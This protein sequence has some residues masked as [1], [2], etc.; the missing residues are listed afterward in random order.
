MAGTLWLPW[1]WLCGRHSGSCGQNSD[2][3]GVKWEE[4]WDGETH[5]IPGSL[6]ACCVISKS[7]ITSLNVPFLIQK[8]TIILSFQF[9]LLVVMLI[10]WNYG[11]ISDRVS[12][13]LPKFGVLWLYLPRTEPRSKTQG[14]WEFRYA[15]LKC[16]ALGRFTM[17]T[18]VTMGTHGFIQYYYAHKK[19]PCGICVSGLARGQRAVQIHKRNHV[20]NGAR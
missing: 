1:T 5:S 10:K 9:N 2:G 3:D 17:E 15:I 16:N 4:H 13:G 18:Q 14:F 11:G 20:G 19:D 7:H 6:L 8:R 12:S